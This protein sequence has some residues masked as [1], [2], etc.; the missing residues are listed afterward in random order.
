[1][2]NVSILRNLSCHDGRTVTQYRWCVQQPCKYVTAGQTSCIHCRISQWC[3]DVTAGPSHP[4]VQLEPMMEW[5]VT[6][7]QGCHDGPSR[8]EIQSEPMME[9]AVP[10][11]QGC[12]CW[13]QISC[14]PTRAQNEGNSSLNAGMS[15]CPQPSS[16]PAR[17]YDGASSPL[18]AGM[19]LLAPAIQQSNQSPW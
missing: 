15:L 17:A 6:T 1:M 18:S 3:R 10:W 7:V 12:H 13:P 11:M 9:W 2:Y 8:P 16:S 4:E 5:A 19:S 14:S